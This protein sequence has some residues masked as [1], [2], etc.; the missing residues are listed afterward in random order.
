MKKDKFNTL[1]REYSRTLSPTQDERDMVT[2]IYQSLD[3]VLGVN[4][5]IQIGSYPRFTSVTPIHDL[6]ILY[7][8]WNWNENLH[9]PLSA[10]QYL[11]KKILLEYKNPTIYKIDISLQSHSVTISHKE[12]NEE[13]FWVDIVPAYIYSKN[14]FWDDTYKVPEIIKTPHKKRLAKY[15]KLS[16][17]HK[18]MDW[19]KSDPRW[20]I[21]VASNLDKTTKGE[22]RKAVK[23]VK[24]WKNNLCEA[25]ENLKFKSFHL[26]QIVTRFF[27]SNSNLEIFD[28]IFNFFIELPSIINNPNQIEDRANSDKFID[29]Y[30][31]KFTYEQK[32]KII[33]ARDWLLIKL[34]KFTWLSSIQS[35]LEIFFYKRV[36]EKEA[37]LFDQKIPV[38]TD[39]SYAFEIYW[40]A[41]PRNW[42]FLGK[43]LDATWLISIDRQID[44]WI[45]WK[46]P[47]VDLFKWKVRNDKISEDPRWEITDYRTLR[48]PEHTK[49][50]WSHYVECYAILDNVCVSRAKQIVRLEK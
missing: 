36:G 4:S 13:I 40:K 10:L 5:C 38:L 34:E 32:E 28:A 42:W 33:Q 11:Y 37:F 45:N 48:N 35:L 12:N 3:D 14:E 1:F 46:E 24:K 22:F 20:Y 47:I 43:V 39:P 15:T 50:P 2:N 21:S 18:N 29:D 41:R 6:D 23:L 25:D 31:E 16:E 9:N 7:F 8:L 17:E 19:I 30:I 49:Y 27:K 44:F 26:E